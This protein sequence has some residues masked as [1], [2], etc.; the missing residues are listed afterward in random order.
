MTANSSQ[1]VVIVGAGLAGL[2]CAK[3][4]WQAGIPV[5][6]LE[7]SD[8]IGGRV[9]TDIVDGFRLDRGFQVLQ[10]A[11]P[12]A[13]EQLDYSKLNLKPFFP[14]AIVRS[15]GKFFKMTDP[16]RR[17]LQALQALFNGIGTF[18][19]RIRL[20]KL[21]SHVMKRDIDAL[22]SG[23]DIPTVEYLRSRGFSEDIIERFFRPWFAGVFL[24]SN[25]STTSRFFNF[26]FRMFSL[27]DSSIPEA[28][29]GEIPRQLASTLHADSIRFNQKVQSVEANQVKLASG[30]AVHGRAVVLAVE[31]PEAMRLAGQ[32][33]GHV[34]SCSTTNL[35]FAADNPPLKG[36][37]IVLNGDG[38]GIINNL[39]VPSNVSPSYAAQ[40]ALVSVS[41]VGPHT[42]E[43]DIV[44]KVSKELEGWFGAQA[45]SWRLLR[46]YV[47]QHALP[48]QPQGTVNQ[49]GA[50]L[51]L[52]N[53]VYVCGDHRQNASINGAMRSGRLV[54]EDLLAASRT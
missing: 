30:E 38:I 11:Y 42:A 12:E 34:A 45:K 28:G 7:A 2:T 24:E 5:N 35:Y 14:G 19:D 23:P 27:G 43:D 36:S 17:P 6:L 52:S 44:G 40:G 49:S 16:W 22:L 33:A 25:L 9:R 31:G 4:L 47:I 37:A 15:R 26:V 3:V 48:A 46:S 41:V 39:C 8:D 53:G 29:M 13:R 18:G 21:R 10:T 20:A 54:A 1:P 32:E 51:R 50:E